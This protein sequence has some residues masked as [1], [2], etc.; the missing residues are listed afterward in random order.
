MN[1]F[2]SGKL[3]EKSK[4]FNFNNFQTTQIH[5]KIILK[6]I[7]KFL[8]AILNAKILKQLFFN[9]NFNTFDNVSSSKY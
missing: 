8:F 1:C 4:A 6:L 2:M 7:F 9:A 3:R 5:I